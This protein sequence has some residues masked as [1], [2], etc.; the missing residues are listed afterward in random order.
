MRLNLD[1]IDEIEGIAYSC[2]E[3]GETEAE[4]VQR[5]DQAGKSWPL[6]PHRLLHDSGA[7]LIAIGLRLKKLSKVG[8]EQDG[9]PA[10]WEDAT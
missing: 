4:P 8:P 1:G 3:Q 5:T 7:A 2:Q 6:M 9:M 10:L